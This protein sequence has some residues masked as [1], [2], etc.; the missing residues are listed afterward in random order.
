MK[1]VIPLFIVFTLLSY[2]ANSN[3]FDSNASK[4]QPEN[5][6]NGINNIY[7]GKIVSPAKYKI[8]AKL[9]TDENLIDVKA[10][11]MWT[12]R[13]AKPTNEIYFNLPRNPNVTDITSSS[14]KIKKLAIN[15]LSSEFIFPDKIGVVKNNGTVA[16]IELLKKVFP[17]ETKQIDIEF[18]LEIPPS[19][20]SWGYAEGRNFYFIADWYPK[21]AVLKDTGWVCYPGDSN[22]GVYSD[23]AD[24]EI[25]II[26]PESYTV[27]GCGIASK[28][29]IANNRTLFKFEQNSIRDFAWFAT[30]DIIN[31]RESYE[32]LSGRSIEIELFIQKEREGYKDR[33]FQAVK[34]SFDFLFENIGEYPYQKFT[35][36][37]VPRTSGS[38]GMVFPTLATFKA[39]LIAPV[40]IH[41]PELKIAEAVAKQYFYGAV[42]VDGYSEQWIESGVPSFLAAQ[43]LENNYD[44]RLNYFEL[45]SY[46]PIFG[47]NFLSY[48]EIPIIYTIGSYQLAPG[49]FSLQEYYKD[50]FVGS[51]AD[52]SYSFPDGLSYKLNT[53][54]KPKLMFLTLASYIGSNKLLNILSNVY[55]EFQF[56]HLS[57]DQFVKCINEESQKNL[58]WFFE[59]LF[60]NSK[61]FDYSVRSIEKISETN[62]EVFVQRSGDGIFRNKIALITKSDTLL[63]Y[64]DG[65]E[66]WK[67]FTFETNNKVIAAV[68][69][70]DRI[71]LFDMNFSNN[72]MMA[73]PNY[74]PPISLAT[75]WFF[76]MQNALMILGSI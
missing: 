50:P 12:N 71:N 68:I 14:I 60:Y 39:P 51:I 23:F 62:Y 53:L 46:Y 44:A 55:Q 20:N 29:S 66:K 27:G 76:W 32:T 1:K 61:Y 41:E 64:W 49:T 13:S 73:S 67:I 24:Y 22:L 25:S 33:Y 2:F 56:K 18:S 37:D 19:K 63:Q 52:K 70:P 69:D 42:A 30:D 17:G 15:N 34:K 40:Y 74:W 6:S 75:R 31:A 38:E 4:I 43:I 48:N 36:V 57:G 9:L 72:S 26:T 11:I 3:L 45:A 7:S 35:V 8:T 10:E 54:H 59:N 65:I 16:K 21:I 5:Y 58:V 28:Q 47:M